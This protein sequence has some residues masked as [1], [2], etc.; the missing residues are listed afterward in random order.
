MNAFIVVIEPDLLAVVS[1][2]PS[3]RPGW[4]VTRSQRSCAPQISHAAF[5]A[6][7]LE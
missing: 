2:G 5:S 7:V 1:A 4:I 3:T 6:T